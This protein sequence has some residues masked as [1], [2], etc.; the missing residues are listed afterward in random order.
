M[1][2]NGH[3]LHTLLFFQAPLHPEAD[4]FSES[5]PNVSL[6]I[7]A[8]YSSLCTQVLHMSLSVWLF[9]SEKPNEMAWYCCA[10]HLAGK[11]LSFKLIVEY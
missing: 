9:Y 8:S 5:C 2:F 1:Y 11:S 10:A 6:F 7:L 4:R 3:N